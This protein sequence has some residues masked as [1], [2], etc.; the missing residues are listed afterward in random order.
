MAVVL[1]A[2]L[3]PAA[4]FSQR[5]GRG[6]GS[7]A[8]SSAKFDF[9]GKVALED[10]TVPSFKVMIESICNGV[11]Y[12][13]MQIGKDGKFRFTLSNS[14]AT[15]DA[16][17]KSLS[18]S[19]VLPEC[20][21]RASAP[22]YKSDSINLYERNY[23]NERAVAQNPDLG[24]IVL[25]KPTGAEA[26]SVSATSQ[27]ASK[28]AKKAFDKGVSGAKDK[29]WDEAA[30]NYQK[31]V[32]LYPEYAE[33]W[34]RLGEA[35]QGQNQADAARKSFETAIKIDAN[36]LPPYAPLVNME[37]QAQ[38]WKNV[39]EMTDRMIK[40][41]PGMPRI[42]LLRVQPVSGESA[43]RQR[44]GHGTAAG[45]ATKSPRG[46]TPSRE[47]VAFSCGVGLRRAMRASCPHEAGMA[48]QRP[49]QRPTPPLFPRYPDPTPRDEIRHAEGDQDSQ[50]HQ[51]PHHHQ[52]CELRA[53]PDVHEEQRHQQ[54]LEDGDRQR[55]HHAERAEI[56]ERHRAGDRR[57]D[58]QRDPDDG[59]SGYGIDVL[60]SFAHG[61][62][63]CRSMRY[64]R[65]KR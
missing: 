42:Y 4:A 60:C 29:K 49:G 13:E 30:K 47:K 26:A 14:N 61:F 23:S 53:V 24:T 48:G 63:P 62:G 6:G 65:G 51:P 38:N 10:G 40:L 39:A 55:H 25:R 2:F 28:D 50:P 17:V 18:D 9:Y 36:Y 41:A 64:S 45:G 58:Q 52:A 7:S 56:D 44:R 3:L 5:G 35:Q 43:L 1:A 8:S 59:V 54:H 31:A 37:A 16:S 46:H 20:N 11:A 12:Q 32:E 33:A 21:I 27:K 22:G 15:V 57:G 19:P 34:F